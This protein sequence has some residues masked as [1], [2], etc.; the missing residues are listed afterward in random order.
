[1]QQR[2]IV[3]ETDIRIGAGEQLVIGL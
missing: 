2:S 3:F 1:V